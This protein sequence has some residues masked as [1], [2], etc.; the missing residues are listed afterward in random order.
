MI[1]AGRRM[2]P[3]RLI[4]GYLAP[5][6]NGQNYIYICI[7]QGPYSVNMINLKIDFVN[8]IQCNPYKP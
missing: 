7:Y 6:N 4:N 1:K 2:Q 8:K 5:L 3:R